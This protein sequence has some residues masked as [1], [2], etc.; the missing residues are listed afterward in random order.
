MRAGQVEV[1]TTRRQLLQFGLGSALAVVLLVW[2]LPHFAQTSWGAIW[3]VI[4]SVPWHHAVGFQALM[5]LGLFCYTFTFT[6]SLRGLTHTKAL[7]VNLCGSSVSNLLPGGGAVGLAATYAICRSWGFSRRATSTSAIVTGVWNVLARI[8]LPVVAIVVLI[9]GGVTLPRALTNLAV[10]GSLTGLGILAAFVA[11][12]VSERSAQWVGAALDRVVGPLVRRRRP[13]STM[14]VEDL[15]RDLR[16]R[17][18][19]VVRWRWW[20]MTLGMVGFFGAYYVLFVLVMRETGVAMPLN[21]L[22]AAYAIGR[23]L[24]AVGITPGGA[25]VTETATTVVLV[26]WGADPAAATAAVVLFSFVTHLMEVPLGGLGWLLW[27][28]SP[29]V[30]PPVEGE[31]PLFPAGSTGVVAPEGQGPHPR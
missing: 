20:S 25:G 10:A 8:A 9:V 23:L 4:R 15:V 17:I 7:V 11:V 6:G 22:F 12:M 21:L 28:L 24:T 5:L 13:R 19:D 2:G 27:S 31:E 3:Q 16:A 29:K 1:P 14:T 18:I 26:G 30:G